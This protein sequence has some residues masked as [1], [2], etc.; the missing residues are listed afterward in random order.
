M[1]DSKRD[2]LTTTPAFGRSGEIERQQE[3][4]ADHYTSLRAVRRD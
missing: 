4:W 1:K 3:G 2:G